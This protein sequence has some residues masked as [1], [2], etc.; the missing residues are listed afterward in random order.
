MGRALPFL[1]VGRVGCGPLEEE[2]VAVAL[3]GPQG[4]AE[5]APERERP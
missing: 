1:T 3:C 2:F 5:P 4:T